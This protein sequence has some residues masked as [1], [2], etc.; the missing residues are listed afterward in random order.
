MACLKRRATEAET[1][2]MKE[3]IAERTKKRRSYIPPKKPGF[4]KQLKGER[5]AIASRYYQL[6]AGHA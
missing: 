5:K 2:G 1:S 4:R 3:W 6:L